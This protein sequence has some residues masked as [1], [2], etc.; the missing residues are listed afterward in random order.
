MLDV[1]YM[2]YR[3]LVVYTLF[4]CTSCFAYRCIALSWSVG[5]LVGGSIIE[6]IGQGDVHTLG[7]H[8]EGAQQIRGA[9]PSRPK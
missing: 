6:R 4:S 1:A 7:V 2:A 9:L 8:H 3:S 5:W